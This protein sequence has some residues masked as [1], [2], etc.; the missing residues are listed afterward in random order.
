MSVAAACRAGGRALAPRPSSAPQAVRDPAGE[1]GAP[2]SF[3]KMSPRSCFLRPARERS[4][5]CAAR[6]AVSRATRCSSS[7]TLP[8]PA[9]VLGVDFWGCPF[10]MTRV[11]VTCRVPAP[12][13]TAD[14]HRPASSPRRRPRVK[15]T[16]TSPPSDCRGWRRGSAGS[17]PR[18][19]S[20]VG[21]PRRSAGEPRRSG[22]ERA[23]R[24]RRRRYRRP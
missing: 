19:K 14:R 2:S 5:F 6:C 16:A 21:P 13:L 10:T 11:A 23:S 4:A 17:P 3:V 20:S 12:R 24:S 9:L 22:F 7:G 1:S 18:S 8:R 15:A